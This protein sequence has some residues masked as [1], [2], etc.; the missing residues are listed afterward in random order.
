MFGQNKLEVTNSYI[1][2]GTNL[3]Y[4]GLFN[5]TIT[6]Y[7]NQSRR[8]VF[9]LTPQARKLY[10]PVDIQCELCDQLVMPILLYGS[11]IRGFQNLDPIERFYGTSLKSLLKLNRRTTNVMVCGVVGRQSVTTVIGKLADKV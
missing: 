5:K 4:N 9:N 1:Y 2:L 10:L 3:N 8:A 7:V 11:E 6:K